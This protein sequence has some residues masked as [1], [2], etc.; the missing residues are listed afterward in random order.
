MQFNDLNERDMPGL[1]DMPMKWDPSVDD[2]D[3]VLDEVADGYDIV[4]NHIQNDCRLYD[5]PASELFAWWLRTMPVRRDSGNEIVTAVLSMNSAYV[6]AITRDSCPE[7]SEDKQ[8]GVFPGQSHCNC[9][10]RGQ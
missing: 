9:Q 3:T 8:P 7:C 4:F 10:Q 2:D 5:I 6:D 1:G